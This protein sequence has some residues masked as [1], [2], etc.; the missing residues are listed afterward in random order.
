M[1]IHGA[2]LGQVTRPGA[3][4]VRIYKSAFWNDRFR[5]KINRFFQSSFGS[6]PNELFIRRT[7]RKAFLGHKKSSGYGT[8]LISPFDLSTEALY[9]VFA[10]CNRQKSGGYNLTSHIGMVT[11][12]ILGL[13][14]IYLLL[15]KCKIDWTGIPPDFHLLLHLPFA[16]TIVGLTLR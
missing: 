12:Y 9:K 14:R 2:P 15:Y 4:L 13:G 1:W 8:S 10:Y 6:I 3:N 11:Q 5:L 7:E 16:L